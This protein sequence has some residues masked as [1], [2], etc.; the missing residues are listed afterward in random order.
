MV[1]LLTREREYFIAIADESHFGRAAV[2]LSI[3][4][5]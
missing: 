4:F 3:D 5:G 2:R 1:A